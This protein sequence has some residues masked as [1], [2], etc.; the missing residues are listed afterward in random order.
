MNEIAYRAGY[1]LYEQ[2]V[3]FVIHLADLLGVTYRDSN[4]LLF[5]VVWPAVTVLLYGWVTWNGFVLWRLRRRRA[6]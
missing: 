1:W 2:C 3:F 4:A 5:F 6:R